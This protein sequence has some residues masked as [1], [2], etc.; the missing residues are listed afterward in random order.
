MSKIVTL[1]VFIFMGFAVSAQNTTATLKGKLVD[2]VNK[3]S[4]KDASI[5][6]LDARDSSLEVFGLAKED[7]SFSIVN[8]GFGAMIVQVKFNGYETFTKNITFS[9]DN[10]TVN[11][12]NIKMVPGANELA[13]VTVTQSAMRMKGDTAEFN[14]S[15]FK[16]KPNAVAEDLIRKM[17][18]MEVAK[19]GSIKSQ[20]EAIQ[21]V[22]VDGKRFMGDDPKLATRNLPPDVIDKIQVF[23][24]MSDQAKFSGFDDGNRVKTL[25]ITTKKDKK[26]GMFGKAVAGIGT[27]DDY[28]DTRYEES[29]NFTKM[30]GDQQLTV[31]G[32]A[33]N[34]NKQN[35]SDNNIGGGR[36]GQGGGGGGNFGGGGG[37]GG[38]RTVLSGG[39]NYR[40]V[41]SPK[42]D[43][44]GSYTFNQ[45]RSNSQSSSNV[46]N[47]LG[48]DTANFN[49]SY[50]SSESRSENHRFSFNFE[51]RIDSV[52]SLIF[53]PN[54]ALQSSNPISASETT[55]LGGKNVENGG[56]NPIYKSVS[57]SSGY[58]SGYNINGSN[59]QLR[60]RFAKRGRTISLDLGF[61][62]STNNGDGNNYSVN[63]FYKPFLKTDTINQHYIDSSRSYSFNPTISYTEPL[64]K[65]SMIELR[66]S[67]NY[68]NSTTI[69]NTYRFD[70]VSQK[71]SKFDSLY[72]NS[73]KYNTASSTANFSYRMQQTKYNFI[74]GTGLQFMDL[75]SNNTTKNVLVK[76]NFVN[77]TPTANFT[78]NF[79]KTRSLRFFY[80]GRTGQ[81]NTSQ[82]QPIVTTSDSI[83]FQVGNPNLKPQFNNNVR[84]LYSS[85]DPFTQRLIFATIN[86]S[87]TTNDI[88]SSITQDLNGSGRKTTTYVNYGATY[89]LGGYFSYGFPLKSPKS[90]LNLQTN[91]NYSKSQSLLNSVA[92]ST[93]SYNLSETVKWTTNLKNNFDMNLSTTFAYN[94]IRN[95]LSPTQNTNYMTQTLAADFTVYSNNG[96]IVA[97][98]FDYTHYMGRPVGYNTTVF[99][100]TPSIAK[101]FL[102]NK[103]GELRLSCFDLLNQNQ[104][105]SVSN[106][107]NQIV[108]SISNTLKRYVM[109]T[110]TYNLRA[111]GQNQRGGQQNMRGQGMPAGG[112]MMMQG[113][114][115][116][117]GNNGGGGR[118]GNNE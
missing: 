78:Y 110:F 88:V 75:E 27:K 47:I 56:T 118:R 115:Q 113:G 40:D 2:S 61:S 35:F 37:G 67:Y 11:L 108:N 32:Q 105:V 1:I 77:F 42:I 24:D 84:L 117:G 107:A 101:T 18:G 31:M 28:G 106:N 64:S 87:I 38:I 16:T 102:K 83:N 96:W 21:R 52:N 41:W 43:A 19:D 62:A 103:A 33:N 100:I 55:T 81:P 26:K 12:G 73:Y 7:G 97:S 72:S 25:N 39:F 44:Y 79:T 34:V 80:N 14:A 109:L 114:M 116:G 94:P 53:R 66:Y 8:I 9:A 112:M 91:I 29:F 23:D 65:N 6:I 89:N 111:F 57:K 76:R 5:T 58:N 4:L 20:G 99:L 49:D 10:S 15:S 45:P 60:H 104:T 68:N 22:T 59:L 13:G 98:D 63:T 36:G 90:N 69:N 50:S 3:Q 85:I 92:N 93:Q 54:F 71:F 70:N 86:G 82:L 17:P 95:S 74:L 46:R 48:A 51:D 30:N